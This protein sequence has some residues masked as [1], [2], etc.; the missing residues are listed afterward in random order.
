MF[1]LSLGSVR[2]ASHVMLLQGVNWHVSSGVVHL[3][4]GDAVQW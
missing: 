4:L 2:A 3:W 1:G